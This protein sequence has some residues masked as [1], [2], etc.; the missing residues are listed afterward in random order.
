MRP[1]SPF[2]YSSLMTTDTSFPALRRSLIRNLEER[3]YTAGRLNNPKRD[4]GHFFGTIL[5]ELKFAVLLAAESD[6]TPEAGRR[7][8]TAASVLEEAAAKFTPEGRIGTINDLNSVSFGLVPYTEA[9]L[10]LRNRI[11]D[12]RWLAL[13][14]AAVRLFDNAAVHI[15]QT[16]DYLNPRGMDALVAVNLHAL[17]GEPRFRDKTAYWLDELAARQYPC[18]AQPYHTAGWIWGRKPAQAYQLLTVTMMLAAGRRLGR[19]DTEAYVKRLMDFET[20][21]CNRRAEPFVTLF[22]GLHKSQ[23]TSCDGWLWPLAFALNEPRFHP[24]GKAVY[25]RWRDRVSTSCPGAVSG[26]VNALLLDVNAIPAA[27]PFIPSQGLHACP[28]ISAIFI[29]EPERDI[30]LSLLT[31]YSSIAEA[32]AGS[33]K[34]YALLPEL[35]DH[36]TYRNTGLDAVRLDWKVPSEQDAC[37]V[38]GNRALL[39]GRGFTKWILSEGPTDAA[40]HLHTRELHIE[41]TY[42]NGELVLSYRTLKNTHP[43]QLP[44]R[45]LFLLIALPRSEAP[46]L[47][48]GNASFTPPPADAKE[49]WSAEAPVGPVTF[50]AADGSAIEIIPEQSRALRLTAERP[51]LELKVENPILATPVKPANE[52]S[53]RLAFEGPDVLE[54]GRYRIRFINGSK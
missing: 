4:P 8:A 40:R 38:D 37:R 24:L 41:L 20:L 34:L 1:P 18:G 25:A 11:P 44:S 29:H 27:A 36:P 9:L 47:R 3:E 39:A 15:N 48:L 21:A 14:E 53:L 32:D 10:R 31:G 22:E 43:E 16:V 54:E 42:E 23:S 46:V 5:P 13:R 19:A 30:G 52:G 7:L 51:H 26:L 17:T 12:G 35:T 45:L 6:D 2:R 28:D 49:P 33:V 50:A